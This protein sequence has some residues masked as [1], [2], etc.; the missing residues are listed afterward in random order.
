MLNEIIAAF[1]GALFFSILFNIDRDSLK[2]GGF[3]GAYSWFCYKVGLYYT[4]N[5][6]MAVFLAAVLVAVLSELAARKLKKPV[7][8]FM[9]PGIVTL[10]PGALAYFT[11]F[12]FVRGDYTSGLA[13]G[14]ETMF[15]AG[16]IAAGIALVSILFRS[17][18]PRVGGRFD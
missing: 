2:Y 13:T 11:M 6:V 4:N 5:S 8:I 15:S 3:A 18:K 17:G 9:I 12:H 10:V 1:V 14:A 7:T 16:A